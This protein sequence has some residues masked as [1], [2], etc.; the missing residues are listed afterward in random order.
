MAMSFN[1]LIGG[2]EISV[3][4]WEDVCVYGE[5][6]F[7]QIT[8]RAQLGKTD[9]VGLGVSRSLYAMIPFDP[10]FLVGRYA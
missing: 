5:C 2:S 7:P 8:H 10:P 3:V 4:K 9:Q 6:E 1:L